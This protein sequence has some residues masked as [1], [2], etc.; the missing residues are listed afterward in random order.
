MK[1]LFI[2]TILGLFNLVDANL[3]SGIGVEAGPSITFQKWTYTDGIEFMNDMDS[4]YNVGI[5]TQFLNFKH[6]NILLDLSYN[7]KGGLQKDV[8]MWNRLDYISLSPEF[9]LKYNVSKFEFVFLIGP[10][11]ELMIHR[12]SYMT[13]D[14]SSKFNKFDFSTPYG[15]GVGYRILKNV[16]MSINFQHQPSIISI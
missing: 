6:V 9:K 12:D 13:N 15:V 16:V 3:I 1:K 14:L 11:F 2:V 8:S 5:Y 4:H 7:Q 10:S